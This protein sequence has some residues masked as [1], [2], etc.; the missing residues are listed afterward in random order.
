L[1]FQKRIVGVPPSTR[2][3]HASAHRRMS[4]EFALR[5][6]AG[7][8]LD[9]QPK[10][11]EGACSS[12]ASGIATLRIVIKREPSARSRFQTPIVQ[13]VN[14]DSFKT[15]FWM[16]QELP[17]I[18]RLSRTTSVAISTVVAGPRQRRER[19]RR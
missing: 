12:K 17:F 14:V 3:H 11:Q 6:T 7:L 10:T 16:P 9:W 1:V 13:T 15:L 2:R 19:R 8:A 4:K 18:V 5:L